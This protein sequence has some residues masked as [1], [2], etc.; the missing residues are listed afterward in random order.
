MKSFFPTLMLLLFCF[1]TSLNATPKAHLN[2]IT[3]GVL[4]VGSSFSN[5]PFINRQ[6]AGLE[7]DLLHAICKQLKLKCEWVEV[8]PDQMMAGL[9]NRQFDLIAGGLVAEQP[10]QFIDFSV[11]Y[12]VTPLS[13]V[14]SKLKNAGI[15]T[16][17][18]LK[19]KSVGVVNRK[20]EEEA[21]KQLL[22]DGQIG[23]LVIYP[24]EE[25]NTSLKDLEKGHVDALL[26][27]YPHAYLLVKEKRSLKIL[28]SLSKPLQKVAFGF[29]K[30]DPQ[31]LTLFNQALQ[32]TQRDGTYTKI[33]KKW[34][35]EVPSEESL[36]LTP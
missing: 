26:L 16:I 10:S 33:Y 24:F 21:A 1:Y 17:Q 36:N 31:L 29:N 8:A 11:P 18:D 9:E 25:M 4:R 15:K 35:H 5:P 19:G 34:F 3:P 14:V 12:L 13:L 30:K 7:V 32:Q 27:L 28:G 20:A 6:K 23:K 2:T 22:N